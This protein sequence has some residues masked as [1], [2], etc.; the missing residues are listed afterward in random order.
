M[1]DAQSPADTATAA[2]L[3]W[4]SIEKGNTNAEVELAGLYARGE[5]VQ[6]SCEQARI[7]LTAAVNKGNA[8]GTAETG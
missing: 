1:R 5:G 8:I 6:K 3:L 2:Q 4:V 7:L